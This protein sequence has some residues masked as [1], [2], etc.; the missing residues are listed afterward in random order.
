MGHRYGSLDSVTKSVL[1]KHV[2]TSPVVN[3]CEKN[4]VN[5]KQALLRWEFQFMFLKY[6]LA[7][8]LARRRKISKFEAL[9]QITIACERLMQKR[10]ILYPI[11]ASDR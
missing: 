1:T 5:D 2:V 4:T 8:T 3:W 9:S 10:G 6:W 7:G 11:K